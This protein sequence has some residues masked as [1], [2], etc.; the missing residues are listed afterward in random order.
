MG[1]VLLKSPCCYFF[2][3]HSACSRGVSDVIIAVPF[4]CF[5]YQVGGAVGGATWGMT[6]L[7]PLL[8]L[9]FPP[10]CHVSSIPVYTDIKNRSFKSFVIVIIPAVFI[11]FIIYTF[12]GIFGLLR[13]DPH[14]ICI[15]SD[16]L[17]NYCP[18]DIP[19]DI[20][21][22]M[23]AVVIVTS[24]PILTFCGRYGVRE[25]GRDSLVSNPMHPPMTMLLAMP[26]LSALKLL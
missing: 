3:T 13:F 6:K 7:P 21:R 15:A 18:T 11:C 25:G 24:Y 23:L 1:E 19:I 4:I 16:I 26:R 22:G 12:A 5:G 8:P 14:D 2:F 10:Q 17:R 9:S 20:A